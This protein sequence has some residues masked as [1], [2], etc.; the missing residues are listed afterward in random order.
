MVTKEKFKLFRELQAIHH[1]NVVACYE[2][3]LSSE[4]FYTVMQRCMGPS[5]VDYVGKVHENQLLADDVRRLASQ[6]LAALGAV[7]RLGVMHRDVKPD[8]FRF[9]DMDAETLQLLDF[10]FAKQAPKTATQHSVT[11][12]LLYVAPEVFD[13]LYSH[14]CDLW[15]AGVLL[16][17]LLVGR[18]PFN[19]CNVSILRC[20]HR[21]PVLMGSDGEL[22]RGDCWE[23]VPVVATDLV[24]GLLMVDTAKRL[25]ADEAMS[26]AWFGS[27]TN[28]ITY[29]RRPSS[30]TLSSNCT[31]NFELKRSCYAWNNLAE[32][33]LSES[34]FESESEFLD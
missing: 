11:G 5:L 3:M 15:S 19:T 32:A 24:R 9:L 4:A 1:P 29:A 26:H 8:N 10:G 27:E 31:V 18:T 33:S 16:F 21:D 20:L 34:N 30:R 13:G 23:E 25:S 6:I 7:H 12:T 17:E 14:K 28:W 2:L 22:F